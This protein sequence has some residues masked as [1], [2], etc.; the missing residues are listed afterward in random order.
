MN[1]SYLLDL[2]RVFA[3]GLVFVAHIGQYLGSDIGGFFG[4]KNFYFV[5][6]GGVGVTLFLILSGLLAGLT[7]ANR[8]TAY[9]SYL[10]KK[11]LRIYPL[12]WLSVISSFIFFITINSSGKWFPSGFSTDLFGSL[13]GFYSWL[14]MWG[15]PYNPPS[16]FIALIMALYGLFP[17]MAW[18]MKKQPHLSLLILFFIS[19]GSRLYVGENGLAF[20]EGHFWDGV[21]EYGYRQFGFMPG[22]PTDWFPLCR[23][24]EFGLGIY[25]ALT[26]N[27]KVWFVLQLPGKKTVAWLSDLSFPLFLVH[28]PMLFLLEWF[29]GLGTP[30]AISAYLIAVTGLAYPLSKLDEKFPRKKLLA[31]S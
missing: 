26:L 4:I 8:K 20:G 24:F 28:Y 29:E 22:R 30:L 12:Y 1:R 5:S 3:I 21:V 6:L 11:V 15:G 16:W 17:L 23:V 7:E 19:I 14:G 9:S 18:A 27:K 2:L 13:T 10:L 25:L 31:K